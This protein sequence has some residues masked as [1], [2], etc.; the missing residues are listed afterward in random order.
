[1]DIPTLKSEAARNVP[2]T[3]SQ[4]FQSIIKMRD[5]ASHT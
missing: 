1:M 2:D 4:K 5:G 3:S